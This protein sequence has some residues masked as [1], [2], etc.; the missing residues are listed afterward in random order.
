MNRELGI[1][2]IS[3]SMI[4]EYMKCPKSFFYKIW[5][6]LKLPQSMRHLEFGTAIHAAIDNIY[7]QYTA[8]D[9]WKNAELA[10]VKKQFIDRFKP[11]HVSIWE[12]QQK[13]EK[14]PDPAQAAA[15]VYK[16][17]YE[18]GLEIIK[19]YWDE[20][21]ELR[22]VHGIDPVKFEVILKIPVFHPE[23]GEKLE[24]P[25]SG[26]L[27]A[28]SEDTSIVEF[29][30]SKA[31]YDE[32]ETRALPQSRSYNL[33]YYCKHGKLPKRLTYVVMLKGR[34]RGGGRIQVLSYEYDKMDICSFFE[35]VKAI[36]AKIRNR[37]FD[38][39]S[40]GHDRWCD[41]TKFDEYLTLKQ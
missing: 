36:L 21:E 4:M 35:E 32:I 34:K 33:M 3:P 31:P 38:K 25:M 19:E 15:E 24:V 28:I 9:G 40:I 18:D 6:G 2:R 12:F 5:L 17:M 20:K 29:K 16:E 7:E 14:Y 8:E 22:A 41:C 37:E 27:D 23:T 26:R 1:N 11:E 10:I 39:P 30:T 13:P